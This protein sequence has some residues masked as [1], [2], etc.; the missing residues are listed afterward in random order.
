MLP[1]GEASTRLPS[2][3]L[4]WQWRRQWRPRQRWWRQLAAV[5]VAVAVAVA[6]RSQRSSIAGIGIVDI[7]EIAM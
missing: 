5:A 4:R 3:P 6:E 7:V 2:R 1:Y